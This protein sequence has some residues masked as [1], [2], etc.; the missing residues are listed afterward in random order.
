MWMFTVR[1]TSDIMVRKTH[2]NVYSITSDFLRQKERPRPGLSRYLNSW[3]L[4]K[5]EHS[6]PGACAYDL[7]PLPLSLGHVQ[8]RGELP[9]DEGTNIILLCSV[10]TTP[11]FRWARQCQKDKPLTA[12]VPSILLQEP[13]CCG[14]GPGPAGWMLFATANLWSWSWANSCNSGPVSMIIFIF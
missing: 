1:V 8:S 14:H 4:G 6:C 2:Y 12:S 13:W 3:M 5:R 9:C 10:P 7:S 11:A